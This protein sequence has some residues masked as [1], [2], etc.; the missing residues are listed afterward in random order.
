M[1]KINITILTAITAIMVI[2]NMYSIIRHYESKAIYYEGLSDIKEQIYRIDSIRDSMYRT[3]H[4]TTVES[5]NH[6]FLMGLD[7]YEN[8]D[9]LTFSDFSDASFVYENKM[10]SIFSLIIK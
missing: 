2:I 4:V 3:Y 9:T 10:D 6:G 5:F 1:K 8:N 7:I